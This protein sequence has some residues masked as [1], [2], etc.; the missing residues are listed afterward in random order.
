MKR[1]KEDYE[2]Y[3][4]TERE[5]AIDS[6][7]MNLKMAKFNLD[8]YKD[9]LEQLEKMYEA[10][11]LT[12]ET[13]EIVL[14]RQKFMVE[15]GEFNYE[16]SKHY[17][18]RTLNVSI[19]RS[20]RDM[21][22]S[23][24]QAE[25]R[26]E[27]AELANQI[28]LSTARYELEKLKS[29][30]KDS[31]DK[32]VKL[33]ADRDLMTITSP[34]TGVVYYGDASDGKWSKI[35]TQKQ[36]LLPGKSADKQAVLITVLDKTK[37]QVVSPLDEKLRISLK[38]GEKVEVQPTPEGSKALTGKVASIS[39]MP[40]ADGK[41]EALFELTTN[42]LPEWLV[43]GMSCEVEVITYQKEDALLVPKKA[44]HDDESKDKKYVWT[45]EEDKPV[46]TWVETGRE[47]GDKVEI[48]SGL[49]TGDVVSLDDEKQEE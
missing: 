43:P 32:H 39:A 48:T 29:A 34:I 33:L 36:K 8:Y 10:D 41:F 9:E 21:K 18:D 47:K 5:Q 23:L 11:D 6:A 4:E 49:S 12:E 25:D 19:P 30:R 42:D 1:A 22:E 40:V 27:S 37:L 31:L 2:R 16:L 20:D 15:Y 13:E 28:D 7:N 3:Q 45:V 35:A 26:V 14:R 46:K 17:H 24:D 38:P 44:I